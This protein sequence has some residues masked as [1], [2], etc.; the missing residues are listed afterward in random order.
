MVSVSRRTLLEASLSDIIATINGWTPIGKPIKSVAGI[1]VKV[2]M[3]KKTST[4]VNLSDK[5]NLDSAAK[6]E[7]ELC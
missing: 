1:E 6:A 5:F 7:C 2:W 3:K 4:D